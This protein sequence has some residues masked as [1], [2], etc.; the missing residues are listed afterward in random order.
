MRRLVAALAAP[1]AFWIGVGTADPRGWWLFGLIWFQSAA[2][3]VYAYLRLE[4][5][6]LKAVPGLAARLR[7]AQRALAYTTFNAAATAV[8]AA[9]GLLPALLPVPYLVQWVEAVW[10]TLNPAV[11]RRPT[12]IGLRQLVVSVIFTIAFILTWR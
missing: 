8:L 4:Q 3:I 1:A 9:L 10:G 11:G 7:M 6:E 5:R 12:A 2:S